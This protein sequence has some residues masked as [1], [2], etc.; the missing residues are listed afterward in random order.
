M[1]NCY[2]VAAKM[3]DGDA[4]FEVDVVSLYP[5]AYEFVPGR[6]WMVSAPH[7]TS[8]MDVGK[9]LG[10]IAGPSGIENASGIVVPA[11]GYLALLTR[12]CGI[13][14]TRLSGGPTQ[15]HM[16]T[17][18]NGSD[19]TAPIVAHSGHRASPCASTRYGK[20]PHSARSSSS[21][22][23]AP[24]GIVVLPTGSSPPRA[25]PDPRRSKATSPR[26]RPECP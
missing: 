23:A 12:T 22:G 3:D 15:S 6:V 1:K 18:R 13:C 24:L 25:V 7:G 4:A 11:I 5:D 26:V 19:E 20:S 2:L 8:A 17:G 21:V 9:T 10:L 14:S 16:R